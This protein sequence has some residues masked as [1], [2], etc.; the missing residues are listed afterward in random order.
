M[1]LRRP[2]TTGEIAKY[3]HV[4]H[5]AVLKWVDAGKLKAYRTPGKHSRVPVDA[6]LEFL[7]SYNMP[8]PSELGSAGDKLKILIVDD[9]KGV[10]EALKRVLALERRYDI[11]TAYE[12]FEAGKKFVEYKPDLVILDLNMPGLNGYDVCAKIRSDEKNDDVK[13]LVISGAVGHEEIKRTMS[14]GADDYLVKPFE[15]QELKTKIAKLL[16]VISD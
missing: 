13:I 14:L 2:L 6:F 10:V 1:I 5:R 7:S 4:T 9:D 8:V 3:C 12:G 11:E 16:G 15:N